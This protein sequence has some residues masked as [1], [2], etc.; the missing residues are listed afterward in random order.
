MR[1]LTSGATTAVIGYL[2]YCGKE[3]IQSHHETEQ[4]R[5]SE[6]QKTTRAQMK[7]NYLLQKTQYIE[8]KKTERAFFKNITTQQKLNTEFNNISPKVENK[9]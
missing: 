8:D 5:I 1:R 2:I 3:H 4:K 7:Y 6:T 9:K